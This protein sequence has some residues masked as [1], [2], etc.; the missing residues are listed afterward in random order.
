LGGLGRS[1]TMWMMK[2]G[3]RNFC[4][5]SRSGADARDAAQLVKDLEAA[6]A[7]IKIVRGDVSV[8]VD[9]QRAVSEISAHYPINGVVHAAMVLR[10]S[11]I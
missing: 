5:L 2:K 4:F 7:V 10:V 11:F 1:L 9:V 3:A 6:G 8:R